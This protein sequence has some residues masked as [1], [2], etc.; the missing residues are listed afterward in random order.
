MEQQPVQRVDEM[1]PRPCCG[2][3]GQRVCELCECLLSQEASDFAL[4]PWLDL[5]FELR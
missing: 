2:P 4:E 1:P 3:D 5:R